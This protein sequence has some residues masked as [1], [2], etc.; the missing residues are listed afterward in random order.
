ML[1]K[2]ENKEYLPIGQS[3]VVLSWSALSNARRTAR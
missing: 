1:E 3:L 2:K